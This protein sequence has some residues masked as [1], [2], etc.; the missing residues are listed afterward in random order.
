MIDRTRLQHHIDGRGEPIG[1]TVRLPGE[2]NQVLPDGRALLQDGTLWIDH[3]M[4]TGPVPSTESRHQGLKNFYG[5]EEGW[6]IVTGS[7]TEEHRSPSGASCAPL[8]A[9]GNPESTW[10]AGVDGILRLHDP[11]GEITSEV[12]LGSTAVDL[13]RSR[14]GRIL[15]T[16]ADG[17]LCDVEE[18][19]R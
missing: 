18:L 9:A 7:I 14:Q 1:S 3:T 5:T 12:E 10:V 19:E 13:Q 16:L 17:R 6:A 15:V 8:A 11:S 4:T 2:V